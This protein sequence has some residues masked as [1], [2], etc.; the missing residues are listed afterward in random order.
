MKSLSK[1]RSYLIELIPELSNLSKE[2]YNDFFLKL[3]ELINTN[4][5]LKEIS[6]LTKEGN[7]ELLY[8]EPL[9][10]NFKYEYLEAKFLGVYITHRNIETDKGIYP[11]GLNT[12]REAELIEYIN[13]KLIVDD[14]YG[15]K[16]ECEDFLSKLNF[17]FPDIAKCLVKLYEDS[18]FQGF[19]KVNF[20]LIEDDEVE[21]TLYF[22]EL[23]T[24]VTLTGGYY[25]SFA[26]IDWVE[27]DYFFSNPSTEINIIYRG[28]S[29]YEIIKGY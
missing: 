22:K 24:L 5:V 15:D 12:K 2:T 9:D 13:S 18:N 8:I 19:E 4:E 27:P 25:T 17:P 6:T 29:P 23:N 16:E 11:L 28:Y 20:R 7:N 26:G 21:I 3:K 1:T 14:F 10:T